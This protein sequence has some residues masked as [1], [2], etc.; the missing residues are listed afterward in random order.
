MAIAVVYAELQE[1]TVATT[2]ANPSFKDVQWLSDHARGEGMVVSCYADTS[3]SSGVRPLW[4]EH[5]KSEVKRIDETLSI[6]RAA[7]TEFH[8]NIAAIEMVLSSRRTASAHGMTIFAASQH[9]LLQA[10]AP[11]VH[12]PEPARHR[13]GAVSGPSPRAAPPATPV[14]GRPHRYASGPAVHR[15]SWR[16]T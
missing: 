14:S 10:Y 5:L 8:R 11:D 1:E 16:C 13:R 9:D 3:V 2:V 4:R 7:R 12:R 15:R 6:D